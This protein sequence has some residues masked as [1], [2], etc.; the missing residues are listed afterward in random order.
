MDDNTLITMKVPLDGIGGEEKLLSNS[1][2]EKPPI[3]QFEG[4]A[5]T[6]VILPD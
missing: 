3:T 4:K 6:P 2:S 1:I 5:E